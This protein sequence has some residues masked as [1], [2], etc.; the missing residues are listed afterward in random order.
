MLNGEFYRTDFSDQLVIDYDASVRSLSFYNLK[1]KSY[2]NNV[3]LETKYTL[4]KGW[5]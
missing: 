1:G 4:L 2:A 5:M 3:Q